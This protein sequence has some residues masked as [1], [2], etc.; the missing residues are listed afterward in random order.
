M[1]TKNYTKI[2]AEISEKIRLLLSGDDLERLPSERYLADRFGVGRRTIRTVLAEL[3]DE[4]LI[5]R[6]QGSGTYTGKPAEAGAT[7]SRELSE[8]TNPLE[9]MDVRIEIEPALARMA[10]IR[11]TPRLIQQLDEIAEKAAYS[12]DVPEWERWDSAFHTKIAA[13][14]GNQLFIAMMDLIDGIR[15]N[16][17]WQQFRSRMRSSRS[18][19]ISVQEHAEIIDAIRRLHPLD[20]EVAM[21]NHLVSL[22][23]TVLLELGGASSHS[24]LHPASAGEAVYDRYNY[25]KET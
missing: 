5:W 9:I 8:H 20:A 10:A 6:R 19:D 1:L 13:A 23:N 11:A 14:S 16:E 24:V 7:S 3:E 2:H 22:R 25:Q 21:R 17:P 15:F 12:T 4:G 18:K